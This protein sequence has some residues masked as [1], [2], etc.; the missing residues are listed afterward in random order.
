MKKVLITLIGLLLLVTHLFG[1]DRAPGINVVYPAGVLDGDQVIDITQPPFNAVGDGVTD[2][3]AAFVAAYDTVINRIKTLCPSLSR[4]NC[5]EL[6]IRI[7]FYV[8]DGTYL[9][10]NT[11]IYSG[12]LFTTNNPNLDRLQHVRFI[13][14]SREKTIIKLQDNAP[15]YQAGADKP[16]FS[17]TKGTF[18]NTANSTSLRNMTVNTGSGNPGAIGVS[19]AGANNCSSYN[20]KI[21][22]EDGSGSVGLDF[23]VG[24]VIGYHRDILIEGFDY[25]IRL[26]PY[27]FTSPTIEHTTIRNQNVAGVLFVDGIGTIRKLKSENTVPAIQ[28]TSPGN[29]AVILD[30]EFRGGSSSNAAIDLQQGHVFA[31][32]VTTSGY[33]SAVKKAGTV[34]VADRYIKEYVSDAIVKWSANSPSVSMNLPIE[35]SPEYWSS[36]LNDWADV[37]DYPSVQEAFDSGKPIIVFSKREY[38]FD[39]TINVPASVRRVVGLYTSIATNARGFMVSEDSSTPV[40]FD[41]MGV[42]GGT[43]VT[44]ACPR[45]IVLNNM[46]SQNRLYQSE[47]SSGK[48]FINACNGLRYSGPLKNVTAF[49]RFVNTESTGTQFLVDNSN[50]VVLGYKTEKLYTSFE[51]INGSRLE[52]L[53]GLP[54]QYATTKGDPL[55]PIIEINNSEVSIVLATNG[56]NDDNVGYENIIRDTQGDIT[57]TWT[58][59]DFPDREGR[60]SDVVVPLYVNHNGPYTSFQSAYV[61]H[62]IPGSI[63]GEHYDVGGEGVAYHDDVSKSGES[64]FRPDDKVDVVAQG[65]ASNGYAVGFSQT[66]EWLEY[67]MDVNPGTYDIILTY[68]SAKSVRGDVQVSLEGDVIGTFSGLVRTASWSTFTTDTIRDVVLDGGNNQVLRLSYVNGKDVNIDAITFV[69]VAPPAPSVPLGQTIWLRSLNTNYYVS[70]NLGQPNIPLQAG[71]ATTAD[72]WEQFVVEDAG[73]GLVALKAVANGRYVAAEATTVNNPLRANRTAVSSWEQFIWQNNPDGTVSLLAK[74]TNKYV[75]T[76]R[77]GE[78]RANRTAAGTWEKYTWGTLSTARTASQSSKSGVETLAS[79]WFSSYPN[80]ASEQLSVAGSEDYQV[81]IYDLTGRKVM[82]HEHLKGVSQLDITYLRAGVYVMKVSDQEHP[83]LRQRIVVE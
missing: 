76:E 3:T 44:Q 40:I 42:K 9:V 8:P 61:P 56:P 14:Q 45:T 54:N 75:A 12:P 17:F 26:V 58:K 19:M 28:C 16:V 41:D 31:R 27:H 38:T 77:T 4:V 10:S 51:A 23:S 32:N 43:A 46:S 66:G 83:Q 1:Q 73:N 81:V 13:G 67:T 49:I 21:V 50:V 74:A 39:N 69:A 18:N 64:S 80:P 78:L 15:G 59:A 22:S 70:A 2:N 36:D 34:A 65:S 63:E 82:Q 62:T 33:G 35:D 68:S 11:L 6:G 30:S 20:L 5:K 37:D 55:N 52:I 71:W 72:T 57:K 48:V 7:T 53:G 47:T 60:P 24:A 29:H 25:G 79:E